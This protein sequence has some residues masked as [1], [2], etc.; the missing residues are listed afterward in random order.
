M[1]RA[2]LDTAKVVAAG[3][4]LADEVGAANLTMGL[5]AQRLG[6]RP[7]SLYKHVTGQDDLERRIATLALTEATERMGT[8]VQGLAGREALAAV[9][10]AFRAYAVEHP[11]RY[12]VGT[13]L[14]PFAAGDD[15][16][17]EARQR[18]QAV[19]EAVLRAYRI[20][21]ADAVHALRT[22]RSLLHGFAS[23]QAADGFQYATD[24][25]ASFEWLV[26]H[27]DRALRVA[28]APADA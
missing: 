2:G 9:M 3:A 14:A 20:P 25:D 21:P 13:G 28:G 11:G 4:A 10:R 24:V 23:I 15:P 1:P 19:L 26:D 7:P 16:L 6:V 12:L 8:A 5:L 27:T 22:V 18:Q 17:G